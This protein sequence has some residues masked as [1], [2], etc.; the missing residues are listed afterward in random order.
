M[1]ICLCCYLSLLS[2]LVKFKCQRTQYMIMSDALRAM[3]NWQRDSNRPQ[4]F[5]WEVGVQ[6]PYEGT[7]IYGRYWPQ[8][9]QQAL[10]KFLSNCR[11]PDNDEDNDNIVTVYYRNRDT[12]QYVLPIWSEV[13]QKEKDRIRIL[14]SKAMQDPDF[15]YL[16]NN[17]YDE[18]YVIKFWVTEN[19]EEV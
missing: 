17:Q 16:E 8:H 14:L 5:F 6:I 7:N 19:L 12:E 11:E 1:I 15:R 13:A 3:I 18:W 2:Q 9:Y 4:G 10:E